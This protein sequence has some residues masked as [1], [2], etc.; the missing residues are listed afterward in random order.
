MILCR[1]LPF[2]AITMNDFVSVAG[3]ETKLSKLFERIT[4]GEVYDSKE[5][6]D[7]A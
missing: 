3:K 7:A 2:S 6:T 5:A 1:L 4:T